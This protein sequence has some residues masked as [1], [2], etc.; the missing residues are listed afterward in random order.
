MS[1]DDDIEIID[2]ERKNLLKNNLQATDEELKALERLIKIQHKKM[3]SN[4]GSRSQPSV[5]IEDFLYH[6]DLGHAID[7]NLLLDFRIR[8]IINLCDCPLDNEIVNV[9]W[10]DDLEDNVQGNIR[11]C[12]DKTNDFLI[13]CK[14]NDEKVLIH[15]QAGISRSSAIVLAYLIKFDSFI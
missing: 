15:C 2:V 14:K 3:N 11:R 4:G 6:G 5:I 9:L 13:E 10:I 7:A 12:F 8:N 1:N